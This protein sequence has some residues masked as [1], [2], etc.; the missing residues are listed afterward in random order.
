MI[1]F[2]D[3][4]FP[5]TKKQEA[6]KKAM[7]EAE[8][9]SYMPKQSAQSAPENAEDKA[10]EAVNIA[11]EEPKA[12]AEAEMA[13][14]G[15]PE[16]A[17]DAQIREQAEATED[18]N[19]AS[20]YSPAESERETADIANISSGST[21]IPVAADINEQPRDAVEPGGD[22]PSENIPELQAQT[23]EAEATDE[24]ANVHQKAEKAGAEVNAACEAE[25]CETP[26]D[27]AK[28]NDAEAEAAVLPDS[29]PSSAPKACPT[30][31]KEQAVEQQDDIRQIL[32]PAAESDNQEFSYE[33]DGRYFAEEE[34][35][36]YK[37][38]AVNTRRR[39][40]PPKQSSNRESITV[41]TKTLIKVGAV[42]A[43]TAAA[44]KLLGK[45]D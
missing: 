8:K 38:G 11:A 9:K 37:Y 32:N 44:V 10:P 2:F 22:S 26:A 3:E 12:A 15:T 29:V 43:A 7:E 39:S 21:Q 27:T 19:A 6:L 42:V 24:A 35:P 13:I 41:S 18:A 31:D 28:P 40:R 36:A 23:H 25:L 5:L 4:D 45:R 30:A 34:T 14:G 16:N 33:Y 20:E 17:V 1:D